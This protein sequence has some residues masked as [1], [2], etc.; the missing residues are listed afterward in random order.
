MREALDGTAIEQV[1][2]VRRGIEESK[3][4]KQGGLAATR[5]A[6]DRNVFSLFDIEM[7]TG[8]GMGFDFVGEEDL[9]NAFE[10]NEGIRHRSDWLELSDWLLGGITHENGM[11]CRKK[12]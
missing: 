4:R 8:E 6:G 3:N 1:S 5:W 11:S 12:L 7:N 2:A 10:F 9:G